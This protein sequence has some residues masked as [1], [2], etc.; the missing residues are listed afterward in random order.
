[1][2]KNQTPQL[3]PQ[4]V[5]ESYNHIELTEDEVVEAMIYA[6]QKKDSLLKLER[7]E[8]ELNKKRE[9]LTQKTNYDLVK[10]LM[11]LRAERKFKP[12][13]VIDDDN[14]FVFEL[15]C[16]YFGD[17]KE[18]ISMC[19]AAG[20]ENASLKKGIMLCGVFGTGKSWMM[21]LFSVNQRQCFDIISA[22]EISEDYR[23]DKNDDPSQDVLHK[24]IVEKQNAFDDP[25]VFYQP[26]RGWCIDDIGAEDLK[27]N[28]GNKKNVIGDIIEIRYQSGEYG[29]SFHATTNLTA[30]QIDEY[31]GG[32]IRSRLREM[33]NFIELKGVD[34]RK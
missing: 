28:F 4:E 29:Q 27:N 12:A 34:R 6:K 19:E 20:I 8:K 10:G 2:E 26:K 13:L 31:Y 25:S 24:Y 9:F 5:L 23:R 15:M 33:F 30:T 11:Q 14:N 22:K 1:M 16:K 17:D 3:T 32:R 21:K 7:Q 18:F